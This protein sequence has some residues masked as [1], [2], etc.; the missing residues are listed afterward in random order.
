MYSVLYRL[1]KPDQIQLVVILV[2]PSFHC[3]PGELT[4]IVGRDGL[5]RPARGDQARPLF[6]DLRPGLRSISRRAKT[7]P[8]ILIHHRQNAEPTAVGPVTLTRTNIGS[9]TMLLH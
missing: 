8:R 4:A 3:L 1:S 7:L 9:L 6:D 2:R 5:R